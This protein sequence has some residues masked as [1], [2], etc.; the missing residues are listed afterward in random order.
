MTEEANT[1]TPSVQAQTPMCGEAITPSSASKGP[2]AISYCVAKSP[3]ARRTRQAAIREGFVNYASPAH[4]EVSSSSDS[5]AV[6]DSSSDS[7]ESDARSSDAD[8]LGDDM[9]SKSKTKR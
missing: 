7:S 6:S 3:R 9:Y 1:P 5:A 4:S 8:D 2:T